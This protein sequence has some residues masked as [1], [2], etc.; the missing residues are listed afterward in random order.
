MTVKFDEKL[1][2]VDEKLEK[3]VERLGSIDTTLAVNTEQLK[4]HIK[5]TNILEAE[6]K[7]I[8]KHVVMMETVFK[9]IGIVCSVVA[10]AAGFFKLVF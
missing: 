2:A 8:S 1:E 6:I 9:A 10:F 4:I 5:R 3:I 7:P